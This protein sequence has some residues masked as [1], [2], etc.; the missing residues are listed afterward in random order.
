MSCHVV[1]IDSANCSLSCR[2]GQ[3]TCK[4]AEGE[5]RLPLEDVASIIITSFPAS[6]HR[7]RQDR[8]FDTCPA[9]P[10][11]LGSGLLYGGEKGS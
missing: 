11:P 8:L 9:P 1:G 3:L 2:D 5:R 7:F 4:T 10:R 6:L